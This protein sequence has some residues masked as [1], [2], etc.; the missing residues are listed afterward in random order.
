MNDLKRVI[1]TVLLSFTFFSTLCMPSPGGHAFPEQLGE[2]VFKLI[3]ANQIDKLDTYLPTKEDW[4]KEKKKLPSTVNVDITVKKKSENMRNGFLKVRQEAVKAGI[5]W[6][7]TKITRILL[8]MKKRRRGLVADVNVY[9]YYEGSEYYFYLSG[10]VKLNR[11]W[12]ITKRI[13]WGRKIN[14][15]LP[16]YYTGEPYIA[17]KNQLEQFC[18]SFFDIVKENKEEELS[19][20]CITKN[21][22]MAVLKNS[23]APKDATKEEL[24]RVDKLVKNYHNEVKKGFLHLRER[25][26]QENLDW[27]TAKVDYITYNIDI[28]RNLHLAKIKIFVSDNKSTY[29]IRISNC[30]KLKQRWVLT[31]KRMGINNK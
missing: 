28:R 23:P 9:F 13:E 1:L 15:K 20:F 8:E 26:V 6:N 11:R 10:C 30:A 22:M 27:K 7:K 31:S 19:R 4:I 18:K 29:T 5:D 25:A 12:V 3:K 17:K 14:E 21:E 2:S 16:Y 24:A